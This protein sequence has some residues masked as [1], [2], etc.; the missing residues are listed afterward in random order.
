MFLQKNE[1]KK[2]KFYDSAYLR[3]HVLRAGYDVTFFGDK[4]MRMSEVY[5]MT[6]KAD[7]DSYR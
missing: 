2:L 1:G 6:R 5:V 7:T 3:Y 4:G